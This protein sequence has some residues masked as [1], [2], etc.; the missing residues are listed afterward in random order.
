MAAEQ[1]MGMPR[2][3]YMVE[4]L[5]GEEIILCPSTRF[6]LILHCVLLPC[7]VQ[8]RIGAFLTEA[9]LGQV[10]VGTRAEL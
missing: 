5:G 2:V 4:S 7:W 10:S 1:G 6:A 3:W 8:V 9:L